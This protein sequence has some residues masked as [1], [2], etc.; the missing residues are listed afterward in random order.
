MSQMPDPAKTAELLVDHYQKTYEVTYELWK[1]RNR[2]FPT[3]AL[4]V[5]GAIILAFHVPQADSLFA[6]VIGSLLRLDPVAQAALQ[7][8]F[9][10]QLLQ[11]VLMVVVFHMLLDL[12]RHNQD[13]TRNYQYL[14]GMEA[15]IRQTMGLAADKIA[16]TRED[17]FYRSHRVVLL[18]GVRVVYSV[19]L[20]VLLALFLYARISDD[21]FRGDA[22]FIAADIIIAIPIVLYFTDYLFPGLLN[23][24]KS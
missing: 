2:L 11:T 12:Y 19:V 1:E 13:I 15:E 10:Y 6:A 18:G 24:K 20:G 22:W 9:T 14:A 23:R 17:A 3:M 5:G 4:V 8:G 7:Q 21:F 16:F